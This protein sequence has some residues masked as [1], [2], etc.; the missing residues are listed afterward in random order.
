MTDRTQDTV[1]LLLRFTAVLFLR[2]K[3]LALAWDDY[4]LIPAYI[5]NVGLVSTGLGL[6]SCVLLLQTIPNGLTPPSSNPPPCRRDRLHR[7]SV[8]AQPRR[9]STLKGRLR[10]L[11]NHQS[12]IC[13]HPFLHSRPL[14]AP[15]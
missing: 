12:G 2:P 8:T 9:D 6:W 1:F 7:R 13:F 5:L 15:L 14:P 4:L 11:P 10:H 3:K